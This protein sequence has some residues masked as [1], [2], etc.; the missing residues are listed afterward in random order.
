M[1]II[2][3]PGPENRNKNSKISDVEKQNLINEFIEILDESGEGEVLTTA[4]IDLDLFNKYINEFPCFHSY[5]GSRDPINLYKSYESSE[6]LSEEQEAALLCVLELTSNFEFGFILS[7]VF[8]TWS[9]PD[10]S[11][12]IRIIS[13]HSILSKDDPA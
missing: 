7:D 10:R 1:S 6:I 4:N 3:F 9:E 8:Q 2:K 11:A 12:F 13:A 5:S